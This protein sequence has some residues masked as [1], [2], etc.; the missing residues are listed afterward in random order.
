MRRITNQAE[1]SG[2]LHF[3]AWRQKQTEGSLFLFE[4]A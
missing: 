3:R 2:R 4:H 1:S